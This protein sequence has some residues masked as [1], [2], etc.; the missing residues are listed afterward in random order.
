M[1]CVRPSREI[2]GIGGFA[3]HFCI[4]A[5]HLRS[6]N[7]IEDFAVIGQNNHRFFFFFFL[8]WSV[9]CEIFF[10]TRKMKKKGVMMPCWIFSGCVSSIWK[11]Y[12]TRPCS[13]VL[14]CVEIVTVFFFFGFSWRVYAPEIPTRIFTPN[15]ARSNNNSNNSNHPKDNNNR[16]NILRVL[17]WLLF[18]QSPSKTDPSPR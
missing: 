11:Y 18:Q 9:A 7:S 2:D 5:V 13:R 16:S 8:S 14:S 12:Q 3:A 17:W 15:C 10:E 4:R 6:G 1:S